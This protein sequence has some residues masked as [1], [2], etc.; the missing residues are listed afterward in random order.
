MSVTP[1]RANPTLTAAHRALATV[2]DP[3]YPGLSIVDLGLVERVE[4]VDETLVVGLIPTF[5]GCPALHMIAADVTAALEAEPEIAACEVQW[6][7]EPAWSTDR[8][9]AVAKDQLASSYTVILRSKDGTLRC[10][11]CGSETV[12]DQ[13]MVGPTRCRSIAWCN[14]CRNPVEV[15]R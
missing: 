13:S 3:E 8:L 14:S 9:T 2:D 7:S 5:A 1:I 15:M 12:T 11:V 6:L 4:L 10:P